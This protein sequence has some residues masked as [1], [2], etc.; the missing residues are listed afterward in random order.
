MTPDPSSSDP[1]SSAAAASAEPAAG[2]VIVHFGEPGSTLSCVESVL[3]DP[4]GLVRD[5]V[6][7]DNSDN[8]PANS[9]PS[10]VHLLRCPDNP[11]FGGGA[12]R[13]VDHLLDPRESSFLFFVVLNHDIEIQPGFLDAAHRALFSKSDLPIGA[14][15]GPI[16]LGQIDGPLWYA[17]GEIRFLTGTVY[18][19]TSPQDADRRRFVRFLTGAAIA[20]EAR[21]WKEVGGYDP[22]IF[23]YNEDL[24]LSLTL[25]RSGRRL[26]FEPD[27]VSVHHLGAATGSSE[28]SPLYLEHLT[29]NRFRPFRSRLYRCYL[30]VLHSGWVA[31][32]ILRF[33]LRGGSGTRARVRALLRGHRRALGSVLR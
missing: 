14:V 32:R 29:A 20:I 4:S 9:L 24:D 21:A 7:V 13:G 10:G 33:L 28:A 19:S 31:F 16:H 5:I 11:G 1:A 27:M 25:H 23:L 26:I 17:G 30:A 6:V 2:V 18:Q 3:R 15:A 22:E 8:F 12:H